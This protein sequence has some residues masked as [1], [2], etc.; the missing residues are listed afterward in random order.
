M[1]N[2]TLL[3]GTGLRTLIMLFAVALTLLVASCEQYT[4]TTVETK[5]SANE[6]A[7]IGALRTISSAQTGFSATHEGDYGSFEELVKA[8]NLDVRFGAE[9]PVIGGYVLTMTVR[10]KDSGAQAGSFTVNADPQQ[11]VAA[12]STGS[13][14]FYM[15]SSDGT[16]HV[17]PK[18]AASSSDPQL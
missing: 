7:A 8:G 11:N 4:K 13:R 3:S 15:A 5:S 9:R 14:H 16:I 1:T 12:G 17:N 10:A 18:Q 6:T 2:T